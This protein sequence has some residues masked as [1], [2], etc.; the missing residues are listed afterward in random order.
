MRL[1]T[2]TYEAELA[3][4]LTGEDILHL[5][6]IVRRVPISRPRRPKYAMRLTRATRVTKPDAPASS[7][8]GSPGAPDRAPAST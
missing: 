6:E 1:T 8:S 3:P 4:V 5:Q 7:R 2:A